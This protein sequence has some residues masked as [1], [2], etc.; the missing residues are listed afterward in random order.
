MNYNTFHLPVFADLINLYFNLSKSSIVFDGTLGFGG[1]AESIL[2]H[3][4]ELK[5]VGFDRDE[6]AIHI[7]KDRCEEFSNFNVIKASFSSIV[8][9]IK[10]NNCC[11][12]HI[13]LDLGISSFQIDQSNRGFSFQQDEPLDMRMDTEQALTAKVVLNTYSKDAL[14]QLFIE[15]GD[16]RLPNRLVDVIIE[17]REK[18]P[19]ETTED[20]K[21]CI[22]Q[23]FKFSSRQ[24]YISMMT[25]VFQA[26]R[27]TVN[28]EMG[29]LKS[30]LNGLLEFK[31]ITVAIITFQPNEDRFVKQFVKE[32]KLERITKKPLQYSY[33][34]CKANPRA[35]SAKLRIFK[36]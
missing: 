18:E 17:Q 2:N 31:G 4:P 7:T 22:K 8:Q 11:P 6:Y 23:S 36:Y 9:Y 27:I 24:R 20:L 19:L 34:E 28:N 16:I 15:E 32:H 30:L 10:L 14:M 29:E 26:I 25:R 1:H 35:K 3:Y 13:L 12:T 5:Y 21:A 33:K